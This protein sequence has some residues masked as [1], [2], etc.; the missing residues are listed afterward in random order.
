MLE[1][2]GENVIKLIL[3]FNT[4]QASCLGQLTFVTELYYVCLLIATSITQ[5]QIDEHIPPIPR[6]L[7][8]P[9]A[10]QNWRAWTPSTFKN[11]TCWYFIWKKSPPPPPKSLKNAEHQPIEDIFRLFKL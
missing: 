8:A 10:E 4:K 6:P 1:L 5:P 2:I 3:V 9:S 7:Q 11:F